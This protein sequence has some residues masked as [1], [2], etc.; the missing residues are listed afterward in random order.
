[1]GL[2]AC[3]PVWVACSSAILAVGELSGLQQSDRCLLAAALAGLCFGFLRQQAS[4][5]LRR[6]LM[7]E[8]RSISLGWRWRLM[9]PSWPR[10]GL[11][12][13]QPA[14][15]PADSF[16]CRWRTCRRVIDGPLM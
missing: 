3:R 1:M 2:D 9:Q 7:G 6:Y 13:R 15:P 14:V 12:S 5:P 4:I 16:R 11:T 10:Q 8:W